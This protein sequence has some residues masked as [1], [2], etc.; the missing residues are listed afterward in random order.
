MAKLITHLTEY[1]KSDSP[2]P[3]QYWMGLFGK[4]NSISYGNAM[5]IGNLTFMFTSSVLDRVIWGG[6]REGI[7]T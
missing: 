2:L 1:L 7:H 5:I 3:L 4:I 6:M